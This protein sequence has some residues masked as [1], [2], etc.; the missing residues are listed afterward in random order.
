VSTENA[1]SY[2]D[3]ALEPV[4]VA[5]HFAAGSYY[6]LKNNEFHSILDNDSKV[7]AGKAVL[8][9]NVAAA[10]VLAIMGAGVTGIKSLNAD[11]IDRWF[12][13]Q[14]NRID[15]PVKKGVYILNGKKVVIK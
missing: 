11:G 8:K 7:P 10:R 4:I 6:A 5:T 14:G 13:L 1:M 9:V 12:D 3:N 15:Q 2:S